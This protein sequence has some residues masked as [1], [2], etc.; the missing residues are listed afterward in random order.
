[1]IFTFKVLVNPGGKLEL[2]VYLAKLTEQRI[3]YDSF[4]VIC[5][6]NCHHEIQLEAE[7][8]HKILDEIPKALDF[9]HVP[10]G[11]M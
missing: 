10:L 2:T 8:H 7:P 4:T 5:K 6:N 1:M 9:G 3:H 11:Y